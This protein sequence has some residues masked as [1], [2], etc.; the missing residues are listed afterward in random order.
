MLQNSRK[1]KPWTKRV[2][3][4]S[5]VATRVSYRHRAFQFSLVRFN[6]CN[7]AVQSHI[8][9]NIDIAFVYR[10]VC[11]SPSVYVPMHLKNTLVWGIVFATSPTTRTTVEGMNRM[12]MPKNLAS[13]LRKSMLKEAWRARSQLAGEFIFRLPFSS[14]NTKT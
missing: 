3:T 10:Q 4:V 5:L 11:P 9:L 12:R 14:S 7:S 1:G 2:F 8:S 6:T 13:H